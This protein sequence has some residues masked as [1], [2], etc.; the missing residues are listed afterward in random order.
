MTVIYRIAFLCLVFSG[1]IIGCAT[2]ESTVVAEAPNIAFSGTLA[3]GNV[4]GERSVQVLSEIETRLL[5]VFPRAKL[6]PNNSNQADV[7]LDINVYSARVIDTR[8]TQETR[9][10]RRWSEPDKDAYSCTTTNRQQFNC[11]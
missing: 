3:S 2:T 7:F 11:K 8:S 5:Q 9:N 10:C 1:G 6:L 4:T